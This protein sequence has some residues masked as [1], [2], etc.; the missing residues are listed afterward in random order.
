MK[1]HLPEQFYSLSDEGKREMVVNGRR[2]AE[3]RDLTDP[4][5][6]AHFITLMWQIG[7]NFFIQKGFAEI[8]ADD[9]LTG[10]QKIDRCYDVPKE[11]AVAAIMNADAVY[12]Y[13]DMV[14]RREELRQ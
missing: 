14:K 13:P 1:T 4:Q 12:W 9:A 7:A 3:S 2:Y 8:F 5:S 6:Q 10:P 11:S